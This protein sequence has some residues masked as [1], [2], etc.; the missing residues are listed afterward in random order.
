[1]LKKM[2]KPMSQNRSHLES[3]Y[4]VAIEA[5]RQ[6]FYRQIQLSEDFFGD[7]NTGASSVAREQALIYQ[8]ALMFLEKNA[9]WILD[10]PEQGEHKCPQNR[11]HSSSLLK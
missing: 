4:R 10:E 9:A 6:E 1:M 8:T 11:K 3:G 2:E 7:G 5:L